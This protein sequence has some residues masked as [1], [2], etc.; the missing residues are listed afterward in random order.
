MSTLALSA[1]SL[2]R[3]AAVA[4]AARAITFCG[5]LA[6]TILLARL[7]ARDANGLVQ[8][9]FVVVQ[10][11]ALLGAS[12]ISSS[13]Y[14]FVPRLDGSGRRTFIGRT[15]AVASSF[16]LIALLFIGF[17]APTI[18]RWMQESE[19]PPLLRAG[20]ASAFL[21]LLA[22]VIDPLLYVEK[23]PGSALAVAACST[24]AQIV[25]AFL[26]LEN[27]APLLWFAMVP[28]AGA[29]FRLIVGSAALLSQRD[30]ALRPETRL[31]TTDAAT[32]RAHYLFLIPVF[33]TGAIDTLSNF[34]DRL[35]VAHYYQAPDLA[36]YVCGAIE[37]PLVGVLLGAITPVLFPEVSGSA[38]GH[39]RAAALQLWRASIRKTSVVL[40]GFL[41][42]LLWVA[43]E[44][45]SFVFSGR[46][47][48]S[49]AYFRIYLALIPLRVAAYLPM[50]MALGSPRAATVAAAG[51][52]LLNLVLSL[53]FM[54]VAGWG[55]A[56]AAWGTVVA[57]YVEVAFC[58]AVI[59]RKLDVGWRDV[60]PWRD[61]GMTFLISAALFAPVMLMK[62]RGIS[63]VPTLS[64]AAVIMVVYW[65]LFA[66]P[67][68][69]GSRP[70]Q[71]S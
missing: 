43:P 70:D 54:R 8:K 65:I 26:C 6:V 63:G 55:M 66:W 44:L 14:Y 16:A 30:A 56:G 27:H 10:M 18:A 29:V 3:R 20:A 48:G 61:L 60:M 32:F 41:F 9:S 2:T 46:Y 1:G 7:L 57:T 5:D 42:A 67:R 68:V 45:F 53:F 17:G 59:R 24:V 64:A 19:L 37:I 62:L 50:L 25:T 21:L 69:A 71:V 38:A 47:S 40:F 12:A 31:P 39:D 34:L 58:L 35:L 13:I 36:V 33:F 28:A 4:G 23:R 52:V 11:A 22:S 49:A 51:E 15:V